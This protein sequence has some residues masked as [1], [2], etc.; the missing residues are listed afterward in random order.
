[1]FCLWLE[2]AFWVWFGLLLL[3][4]LLL[5]LLLVCFLVVAWIT[6]SFERI[7]MLLACLLS[8]FMRTSIAYYNADQVPTISTELLWTADYVIPTSVHMPAIACLFVLFCFCFVL[9][10]VCSVLLLLNFMYLYAATYL[11]MPVELR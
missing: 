5:F 8:N 3:L 4:L 7:P 9:F 2:F 1:V 6:F 10:F 11:P